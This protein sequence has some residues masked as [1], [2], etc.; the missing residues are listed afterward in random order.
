MTSPLHFPILRVLLPADEAW[1]I[2][3][4]YGFAA[5]GTLSAQGE[6]VLAEVPAAG[7]LEI[8]LPARC[9]S[10]HR[11]TLPAQ[12]GKHLD[13]LIGQAL[14][15]RLLGNK[16]DVLAIP[17]PQQGTE[18]RVWVCSRRWL[19]G[20]LERLAE[21]GLHPTRLIPEYELLPE[22]TDA[23]TC[24]MA[25]G[26]TIFRTS[27]GQFG[28]VHDEE[29]IP[30]LT[31]GAP[32]QVLDSIDCRPCPASCRGS[33]PKSLGRFAK[34][35]FDVKL[36]RKSAVLLATS[37]ALLLLGTV[38]HWRQLESREARLQHEIRQTFAT[39]YPGTPIIDP[40]LQWESKQREGGQGR[41]DA[42]DAVIHLAARLNAP[43]RPRRIESGEGFVR[44]TLTDSEVAQFKMQLDAF[45]K[46]ETSPAESGFT[47]LTYRLDR[48]SR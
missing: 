28:I 42:L 36:L 16:S 9:V 7:E 23:T 11:L 44:L 32:V 30:A 13:A 2:L 4:W 22:T 14:E 6:S 33:L 40:L 8:L 35:G 47:R 5:D 3:D 15:D 37:A 25:T 17:G 34:R 38:I 41:G 20:A 18:R 46:P 1:T 19:E 27:S 10:L 29:S 31:G 26:G 21:A 24:A 12:A 43:I 39:A 45:G 48:A